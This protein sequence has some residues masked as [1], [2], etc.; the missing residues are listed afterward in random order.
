MANVSRIILDHPALGTAGGAGL[1]ASIQAIY[2]KLGDSIADRLFYAENLASAG[3]VDLVHNYG[4][5]LADIR[6]DL[7][8]WDTTTQVLTRIT[9]SSSP[10]LS[11][12]VVAEKSGAEK[13]TLT[14]TNSS[15]AERDLVLCA[16]HDP[17]GLGELTDIDLTTPA[18]DG[19]GLVW[20][21]IAGKFKPGAS[22]DASFKLQSISTP[23]ATIKGGYLLLDDGRELATY[24]GAGSASTDYGKDLVVSLSTVLG[25]SPADATAYYLYIDLSTLG[26]AVTQS[27]SGRKVYA[28]TI[29]NLVL[30]TTT[31]DLMD[32]AR[33][34]PLH[35]IKSAT[36]GTAWSGSGSFFATL[37]YLGRNTLDAQALQ[38]LSKSYIY[39]G[40]AEGDVSDW[41]TYADAA[42]AVPVDGTGGSPNVT[43]TRNTTSP[44][45][46]IA[47]FKFSKDAANRQGQGFSR[48]FTIPATDKGI[49]A[50]MRFR[51]NASATNY[52]AGDLVMYVYDVTNSM[53]VKPAVTSLPK[54]ANIFDTSFDLTTGTSYRL[55]GHVA[56][57]NASAYDVYFDDF[58]VD[59]ERTGTGAAVGPITQFTPTW[60]ADSGLS[61]T[62]RGSYQIIGDAMHLK[63][64]AY[65][66]GT[67]ATAGDFRMDLPTVDGSTVTGKTGSYATGNLNLSGVESSNLFA[68]FPSDSTQLRFA[69]TTAPTS[70][71]QGTGMGDVGT[72]YNTID[73]DVII[74]IVELTGRGTLNLL[75]ESVVQSNV[76]VQATN[77]S[78]G[79]TASG[80]EVTAIYSTE[81]KDSHN[82]YDPTTG[83]FTAP[84]AGDYHVEARFGWDG[85]G[86][87]SIAMYIRKNSTN[88]KL[89]E[90]ISANYAAISGVVSC[91][92]GDTISIRTFYS[93]GT[94]PRTPVNSVAAQNLEISRIA[95][96]SAGDAVGYGQLTGTQSGLYP[97]AASNLDDVAATKLGL[98]TYSHGTTY[99]GGNA[100]T[101]T[102]A[103]GGGTLN[104]VNLA[105]FIPYQVQDGSWRMKFN[106][107]VTLSS[108]T[109]TT[110]GVFIN[111]IL[112]PTSAGDGQAISASS[113]ST[114]NA[115]SY[116]L[117]LQNSNGIYIQHSSVTSAKYC[118]SGDIKLASKPTWAY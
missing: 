63:V 88:I 49:K 39:P 13:T 86:T 57:T 16:Y 7:Y 101:V 85:S 55:I 108:T 22:G 54:A 28:I 19:Q 113:T 93:S 65:L 6:W 44:I 115:I 94:S 26:A 100:P 103:A 4:V 87:N 53:L 60:A 40:T 10:A 96:Y 23:N 111:G 77:T 89:A 106:V 73:L 114:T 79:S 12:F 25:G 110:A 90:W 33:Y 30:R 107:D 75:S 41:V 118:F 59:I 45:R 43:F 83:I 68:Y 3:T 38:A 67:G 98:K 34:L 105:D 27:D 56:T 95:D 61:I 70:A 11:S 14:L 58:R 109:R 112:I 29:S 46:G 76:R 50:R 51:F 104:T 102:L 47:D 42:G 62:S 82:A 35:V 52:A 17:I 97:A 31:P 48:A 36:T 64:S 66:A 81:V 116:G 69:S 72:R 92:K 15:G 74:P 71:I 91:A 84:V 20:D 21:A 18:E 8:L 80:V 99:N 37:A 24:D 9:S 117:A 78:N 1:H 5:G 32:R 2:K